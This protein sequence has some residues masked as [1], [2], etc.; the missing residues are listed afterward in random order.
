MRG[1][2]ETFLTTDHA[3]ID[4]LLAKAERADRSIESEVYAQFR[5]ALLRHIAMEEKVLLPYAR[6]RRGGE[7][8]PVARALRK[9]HGAIAA[10]LVP[11]PTPTLCADLRAVLARHNPLEEGSE[12]LYAVCDVLAGDDAEQVVVRLRAQPDVPMAPHY[13]GPLVSKHRPPSS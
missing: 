5:Q 13:D 12:G 10:L 3:R 4:A 9:D 2:I 1:P 8:L 11:S 6:D 7:P